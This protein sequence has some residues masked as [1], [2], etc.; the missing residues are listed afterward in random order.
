M[1]VNRGRYEYYDFPFCKPKIVMP[2]F[3]TLGQAGS[4]PQYE[5]GVAGLRV[6]SYQGPTRNLGMQGLEFK[7]SWGLIALH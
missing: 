2:H 6:S 3:M 7:V 5:M 4:P 1:T